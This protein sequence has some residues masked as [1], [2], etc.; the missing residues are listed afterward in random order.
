MIHDSQA[1]LLLNML[2]N[3]SMFNV[4]STKPHKNDI[5]SVCM[6]LSFP[7]LPGQKRLSINMFS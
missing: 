4:K 1:E 2:N 6:F 3:P 5:L 7:L